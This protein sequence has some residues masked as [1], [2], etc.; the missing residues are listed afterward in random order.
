MNGTQKFGHNMLL[1]EL[2]LAFTLSSLIAGPAAKAQNVLLVS[3]HTGAANHNALS[4]PGQM[5]EQLAAAERK[6]L[7]R[8]YER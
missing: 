1:R 2:I 4:G 6:L 7:Q 5:E 8:T 3:N